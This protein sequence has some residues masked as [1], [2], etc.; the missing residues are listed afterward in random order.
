MGDAFAY[1]RPFRTYRTPITGVFHVGPSYRTA[2][3]QQYT[4]SHSEIGVRAVRQL[5]GLRYSLLNQSYLLFCQCHHGYSLFIACLIAC[6]RNY[7]VYYLAP[8]FSFLFFIFHISYFQHHPIS[9]NMFLNFFSSFPADSDVNPKRKDEKGH[10]EGSNRAHRVI[11]SFYK[12]SGLKHASRLL[13]ISRS[14]LCWLFFNG[15]KHRFN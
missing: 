10:R 4:T 11:W 15:M 7:F 3:F 6:F 13:S 8:F 14:I 2:I 5:S 1:G 9:G 12:G